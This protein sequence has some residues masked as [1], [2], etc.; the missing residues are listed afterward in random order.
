MLKFIET[1]FAFFFSFSKMKND[2][3][4]VE[5]EECQRM[6]SRKFYSTVPLYFYAAYYDFKFT[7][8]ILFFAKFLFYS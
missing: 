1:N 4:Y 8:R 2:F 7:D 3:C 6:M 5:K